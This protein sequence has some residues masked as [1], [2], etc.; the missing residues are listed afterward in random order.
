M[1][2]DGNVEVEELSHPLQ[3]STC[4]T[5][6]PTMDLISF[7]LNDGV[8]LIYRRGNEKV[9]DIEYT[10]PI[11]NKNDENDTLRKFKKLVWKPNGRYFSV[12]STDGLINIYNTM[13]G[14]LIRSI[15]L[16]MD[17]SCLMWVEKGLDT[18][19]KN[20]NNEKGFGMLNDLNIINSLPQLKLDSN[21]KNESDVKYDKSLENTSSLDFI[22]AGSSNGSLSCIFSGIFVVENLTL[23]EVFENSQI[24]DILSNTSLSNH[25]ILLKTLPNNDISLLKLNTDFINKDN[26]FTK[27]LLICSKLLNLIDYIKSSVNQ[28][29]NHYKPYFDYSIR[30]IELL[31]GEINDEG[32]INGNINDSNNTDPIYDLYDLLL[33]GSLSNATKKWLTDYLGDRGIKR[34]TK[35]GRAYFDNA[36]NSIYNDLISSLHHMI[37]FLTDLKGLSQWKLDVTSLYTLD[38]DECIKILQNY[39]KYSYKFM[40]D[41][42][43]NQRY[44]EQTIIWLTSIL[45][46]ITTDEKLNVNFKTNDITKFLM[47][48]SSK[49]NSVNQSNNS[50]NIHDASKLI[51]FTDFL[52]KVL[53]SLFGKIKNDIKSRFKLDKHSLV[54]SDTILIDNIKMIIFNE[55]NKGYILMILEN[56]TIGIK[57]FDLLDLEIVTHMISLPDVNNQD[58]VD[59]DIITDTEL[60]VLFEDSVILYQLFCDT[61]NATIKYKYILN[62]YYD[63]SD[64]EFRGA[65][66]AVNRMSR[67]FCV[68]DKSKKKYMWIKF[69]NL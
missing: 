32:D 67:T 31:R 23:T 17:I 27:I 42:N 56:C 52:D 39:L 69:V 49:V 35:L 54:M 6:C 3:C 29:T 60:L 43:D 63:E 30:I 11:T 44:F 22:I 19:N 50:N 47:F 21:V 2:T 25:Y 26:E 46:E 8:I 59:L 65:Y 68:L 53:N 37:V 61:D 7:Q 4:F 55:I 14:S 16:N 13:D 12:V 10:N 20:Q 58:I 38:I 5:L 1:N 34:W 33:T 18:Y 66:L 45:S 41:L 51:E 62:D 36:R 9:W 57:I 24:L 48:I 40:M 64:N 15:Q 28:I